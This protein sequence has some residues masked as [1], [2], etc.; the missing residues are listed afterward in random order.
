VILLEAENRQNGDIMATIESR[1][2][3][4]NSHLIRGMLIEI[5]IMAKDISLD[6]FN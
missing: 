6:A 4:I 3:T 5:F 1:I 2:A